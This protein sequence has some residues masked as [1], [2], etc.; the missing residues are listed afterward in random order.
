MRFSST[1]VTA[2][3]RSGATSENASNTTAQFGNATFTIPG[4]EGDPVQLR[5]LRHDAQHYRDD[6]MRLNAGT[7]AVVSHDRLR[8]K[9]LGSKCMPATI[10]F[11]PA[12]ILASSA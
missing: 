2:A 10:T 1:T 9:P 5:F 8:A 7:G 4:K 3:G 11:I 6:Q 12:H